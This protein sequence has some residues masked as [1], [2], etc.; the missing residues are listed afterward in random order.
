[1]NRCVNI[2]W[3]EVY[4]IEQKPCWPNIFRDAGYEVKEREYGTPMY[5]SMFT[6]YRQGQP[7]IEIRRQPYSVR[8]QGGIF[9]DGSTHIRLCNRFCY[10]PSPV[11]ELRAFLLAFDYFLVGIS[12]LDICLDF[13]KFDKGDD[14]RNFLRAFFRGEVRKINQSNISAHGKDAWDGQIWNSLKWGSPSSM[15]STKLYDKTLEMKEHGQYK[16]Y[17]VDQWAQAHLAEY[18]AVTVTVTD[19]KTKQQNTQLRQVVVPWQPPEALAAQ[20]RARSVPVPIDQVHQARV[21]RVEFSIKSEGRHWIDL[22]GG[23]QI[24]L[25]LLQIDNRQKLLF[26]FHSLAAHYFRFKRLVR[27]AD[28]SP[29]RKDRCPD[30]ILFITNDREAA[31]K[32]KHL[33]M[34]RDLTRMDRIIYHKLLDLS[35]DYDNLTPEQRRCCYTIADLIREQTMSVYANITTDKIHENISS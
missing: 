17:I 11:D 1:M 3:L 19:P 2:D 22:T 35:S 13:L 34:T 21:W 26:I 12:R 4:C 5:Q 32:P 24:D 7:F 18:Q 25:S 31:Y 29:Q 6:L 10:S 8:S 28:G 23:R 33:A 20:G 14:P 30:K 9:E 16:A 27:K 15:V